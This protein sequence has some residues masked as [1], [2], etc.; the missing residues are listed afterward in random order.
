MRLTGIF[1]SSPMYISHIGCGITSYCCKVVYLS[2]LHDVKL[3]FHLESENI[4]LRIFE[5]ENIIVKWWIIFLISICFKRMMHQSTDM[6]FMKEIKILQIELLSY[7]FF[8]KKFALNDSLWI[9][10]LLF[11]NLKGKM[12]VM[13]PEWWIYK[14]FMHSFPSFSNSKSLCAVIATSANSIKLARQKSN[15]E[16][17][18][19]IELP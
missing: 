7:R 8:H 9:G 15:G 10:F 4:L 16:L 13:F 17:P 19:L 11:E 18:S 5:S 12:N 1:L 3:T 6:D 2:T 14:L